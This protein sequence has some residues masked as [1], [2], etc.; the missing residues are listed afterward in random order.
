MADSGYTMA[1]INDLAA[2]GSVDLLDGIRG[3]I[4]PENMVILAY[5]SQELVDGRFTCTVGSQQV[6]N[7]T[8][9]TV[10]A[11]V[12]ITPQIPDDLMIVT[13]GEVGEQIILTYENPDASAREGRAIV[14]ALP[15]DDAILIRG[16]A[17]SLGL[18]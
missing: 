1:V 18:S 14:F 11:T 3:S 13:L 16:L 9:A 4:L 5:L 6:L 7:R 2:G 17:G 12:G 8:P 10:Q 15:V